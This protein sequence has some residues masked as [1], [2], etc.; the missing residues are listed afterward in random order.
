MILQCNISCAIKAV[1]A[2]EPLAPKVN[3]NKQNKLK[4]TR[5]S[6]LK[7]VINSKTAQNSNIV[8]VKV[9]NSKIRVRD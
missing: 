5:I 4:K 3:Y 2:L 1:F 7:I 8:E 6:Q 9:N